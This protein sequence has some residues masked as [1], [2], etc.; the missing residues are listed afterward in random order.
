VLGSIIYNIWHTRNEIKHLDQPSSEE[1]ILKK[2]FWEARTRIAG[3]GKFPKTRG[4]LVLASLLN[5]P[6][7]LIL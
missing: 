2:V 6:T 5:L 4:N 7:E 3:K 1:Q